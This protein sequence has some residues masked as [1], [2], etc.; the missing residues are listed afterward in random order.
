M[1]IEIN[2][3]K[4]IT[5]NKNRKK[6]DNLH[7][8]TSESE[9]INIIVENDFFFENHLKIDKIIQKIPNN[10]EYF[11]LID[12][13]QNINYKNL[14]D[15]NTYYKLNQEKT[16][17]IMIEYKLG[18]FSHFIDFFKSLPIPKLFIY[19][20]IDSYIHILNEFNI[21]INNDIFLFDLTSKNIIFDNTLKPKLINFEFALYNELKKTNFINILNKTNNYSL[22]PIEIHFLFYIYSNNIEYI[23]IT[24]L[25]N[26]INNFVNN[27][28]F[29][30]LFSP[31]YKEQ[32]KEESLKYLNIF[33]N[34]PSQYVYDEIIKYKHT[35]SNYSLSI[36][37]IYIIGKTI[38][39]F[40]LKNTIIN[41]ILLILNKN[42]HPNPLKRENVSQT[43]EKM[44]ILFGEF[45]DWNFI[46][47]ISSMNKEYYQLIKDL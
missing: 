16:D 18:D 38:K 21:L 25:S 32:Y 9:E 27:M 13:I 35:W 4:K 30:D 26:I 36:I 17:F 41:K 5:E 2:M 28:P 31:K 45:N 39:T 37:Y 1:D 22:K 42:I 23:S 15:K 6:E 12:E 46:K 34:K 44:D 10:K 8:K 29:F 24:F 43:I 40:Q 3:L 47:N 33:V 19:H 7:K 11:I 20:L 14:Y